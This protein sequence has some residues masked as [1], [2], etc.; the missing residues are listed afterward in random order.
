LE[1]TIVEKR[2]ECLIGHAG[3]LSVCI[4]RGPPTVTALRALERESAVLIDRHQRISRLDVVRPY[5]HASRAEEVQALEVELAAQIGE[6]CVGLAVVIEGSGVGAAIA[7]GERARLLPHLHAPTETFPRVAD[8]LQWIARLP[9]QDPRLYAAPAL[10]ADVEL[11]G[12][13][14]DEG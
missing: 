7:H 4:W 12:R 9:G 3:P 5:R 8:A 11:L 14:D 1:L 13:G 2:P 10:A 6:R